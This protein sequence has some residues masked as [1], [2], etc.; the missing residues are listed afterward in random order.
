MKVPLASSTTA[1]ASVVLFVALSVVSPPQPTAAEQVRNTQDQIAPW[2]IV[3]F[4]ALLDWVT[5]HAR[6]AVRRTSARV[7]RCCYLPAAPLDGRSP[8]ASSEPHPAVPTSETRTTNAVD[9][10]LP[11]FL[12]GHG[13]A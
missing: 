5:C 12:L 9:R 10:M 1:G 2:Y 11:P 13:S 4:L 3:A 7:S 6:R 8:V